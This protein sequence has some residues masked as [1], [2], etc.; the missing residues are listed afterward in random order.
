MRSKYNNEPVNSFSAINICLAYFQAMVLA[1][2]IDS[3]YL[4]TVF[5]SMKYPALDPIMFL[6]YKKTLLFS[7]FCWCFLNTTSYISI[8]QPSP[9]FMFIFTKLCMY[10]GA[11]ETAQ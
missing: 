5:I 11:G 4:L 6:Y 9:T 3:L 8:F 7:T 1:T 10:R 2:Y